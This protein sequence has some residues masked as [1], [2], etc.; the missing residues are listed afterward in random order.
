MKLQFDYIW[1]PSALGGHNSPPYEGMRT[2][3][4]WQKYLNEF[5]SCARDV[6]WIEFSFDPETL[7]GKATCKFT[8]EDP[9]PDAWLRDG[10]LIELLSGFRVLAVGRITN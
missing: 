8:M 3:I 9:V 5:L 7:Q 4:R 10:E 2:T 1:I 6:Q